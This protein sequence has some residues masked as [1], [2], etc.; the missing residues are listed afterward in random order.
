A[1]ATTRRWIIACWHQPPYTK[2]SHDSDIEEQLIWARE[3]LLPLLE[4]SGVDLVLGGHSHSYERSRFIDG[5]YATPTLA[6]SG[7]T[8]DNGDGQVHGDGAYGKDYGGHRGAVYAVAGSSGKL[9]GGPLDHPVMFRSLN[10]LG[11]MIISIDGN[12]LDAKFI[13]HLGVIEDQ[14]RIEK[15]PL[16]TLS[17]LIPD[18]AEYGPVTGKI[19]VARSGSTTN[20]LNVQLEISGTAPE[21][22]YAPVTIPVTIPSGVT[23][24][25]VNIIPLPNASVQGTQTVVLSGVPNVA[26]RLSASTNATVSISDTPPDAPPIANW[27]LA[28]FG[29]DGNNP[30]VTGND[31]DLDGDGLPNLLEYALVHDPAVTNIPIAAGMVSNQWIILFRHDTTRTDVNLEL[32]LSD[33]LLQSGWTPVVRTLGGAP[34]ETLNGATLIRETGGNPG[35]VEVRLPSNLPKAYIRWQAS[36]IPL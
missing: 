26:Y 31:V 32:Q 28:Q 8:I 20:P 18:A 22:R 17:T 21:T 13:N 6:D 19:S 23:S 5:F 29:A 25:V 2:G 10:Q 16:V 30:N 4:A 35:T 24:Q 14:F 34:V 7:T 9:S 33:D 11:S 27:N 15:G 1:A 3:N 12:R 36:P